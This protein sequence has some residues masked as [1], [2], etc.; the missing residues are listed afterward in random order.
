M[1]YKQKCW[2]GYVAKGTKKSPSGKMTKGGKIKRVN[3]CVKK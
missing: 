2:N 1:A 3:N